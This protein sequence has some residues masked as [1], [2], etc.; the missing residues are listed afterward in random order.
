VLR[1]PAVALLVATSFLAA[2]PPVRAQ[3]V[4]T[5]YV[6]ELVV[7]SLG[8]PT[9]I[10]FTPDGRMLVSTQPG[11]LRVFTATGT[12]LAT[13]H[14]FP[15]S[16]I[17][18]NSERGLLGI[19]VHPDF[20]SNRYVYLFY[21]FERPDGSCVNRV[22][23]FQFQA[24]PSQNLL[25]AGSETIIV[26]GILSPAG[27]HNAGDLNF[28]PDG[29][30]YISTGDGGSMPHLSQALN[31][32]NGK[33]LRVGDDPD[34]TPLDNPVWTQPDGQPLF[35]EKCWQNGST[36]SNSYCGEIWATGFR[37]PFRFAIDPNSPTLRLFVNDVGQNTWEEIDDVAKRGNYGWSP[38]EGNH[39]TGTTAAGCEGLPPYPTAVQGHR[40]PAFEW[41]HN[42]TVPGMTASGCNSITGAAFVP[43]DLWADQIGSSFDGDYFFA[44][45]VCDVIGRLTFDGSA[46]TAA[47]FASGLG[48]VTHLEFGPH[49]DGGAL[50]YATFDDGGS[51]HRISQGDPDANDPPVAAIDATPTS[52]ATPLLVTFDATG[53]S[54]P[55]A[56]DTLTYLWDFGDETPVV[57]TSTAG[58]THTYTSGG[59]YTAQL[60]VR[61][62]DFA[63]SAPVTVEIQ[64]DNTPPEL[65]ITS[66]AAGYEFSSEEAIQLQGSGTDAQDGGVPT[67]QLTW[68]VIAHDPP[69]S[70]TI[71]GPTTGNLLWFDAPE[72]ASLAAADT[73]YIEIKLSATDSQGLTGTTSRVLQPNKVTIEI[74]TVPTGLELDVFGSTVTA[75]L[76]FT[77][78]ENWLIPLQAYHQEL[79]GD[80]YV[81]QR[82]GSNILSPFIELV[83]PDQGSYSIA[84]TFVESVDSGPTHFY[85]VEPCRAVDTRDPDGPF[86]GPWLTIATPRTFVIPGNRCGIPAGVLGIAANVTVVGAPGQGNLGIY[87]AGDDGSSTSVL[88]FR[89]GRNV[90]NNVVLRPGDADG[91][92]AEMRGASGHL[93]I[94][95]V[96][97]FVAVTP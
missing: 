23:R 7:G 32:L 92:I 97:Y 52:G 66:P 55:D 42:S 34:E 65:T 16:S 36:L 76:S 29:H 26:D 13:A 17:C 72:P 74:D 61:D 69:A 88:N 82:W 2:A 59:V 62:Q 24:P 67:S 14:T 19:A 96:G 31:T 84:A 68:E 73:T 90:A 12:L 80:L 77:A 5:G 27:N 45:Y 85:T 9:A 56:G 83:A 25:A 38:C 30:L 46:W 53:S 21:T 71:F 35:G 89:T 20:A 10:A 6:D 3:T 1:A 75:P 60:R 81:F 93:V 15:S 37:N 57:T 95:V 64:P 39:D 49:G 44:D 54:D 91:V 94:D 87:P 18:T 43:D 58:T 11:V 48:A 22:S 33:I 79:G 70:Q 4:P 40:P 78:W 86:G 63:F 8:T 51:I 28:G 41:Q 47:N 50:Y